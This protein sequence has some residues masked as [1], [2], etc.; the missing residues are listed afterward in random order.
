MI[1]LGIDPGYRNL[2]LAILRVSEFKAEHLWS[3]TWSVG[4]SSSGINFAKLLWPRLEKLDMRF[5]IEAIA[6]E[7]PP[8]IMRQIKTTALLWAVSTVITS[9][10]VHRGIPFKHAA[11]IALKRGTSRAL[12]LPWNPKYIPKKKDIKLVVKQYCDTSGRTNHEDDAALA[13]ILLYTK[14]IPN[15]PAC[16][17]RT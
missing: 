4:S 10:A 8:F 14:L 2:G 7:T 5:D 15:A 6:S 12:K 17:Q 11:P 3:E 13:A 16:A 9:W 1:V